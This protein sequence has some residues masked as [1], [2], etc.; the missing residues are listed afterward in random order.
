VSEL[1]SFL[2]VSLSKTLGQVGC[3]THQVPKNINTVVCLFVYFS[4][5]IFHTEGVCS[6]RCPDPDRTLALDGLRQERMRRM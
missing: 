4:F 3:P 2:L 1:V 5:T 6:G